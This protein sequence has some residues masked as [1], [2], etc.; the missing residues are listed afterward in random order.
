MAGLSTS[1]TRQFTLVPV[2]L[3][4]LEGCSLYRLVKGG[5]EVPFVLAYGFAFLHKV[6]SSKTLSFRVMKNSSSHAERFPKTLFAL[7]RT[8]SEGRVVPETCSPI[9]RCTP[10]SGM[11]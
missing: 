5:F 7:S 11:E 8:G 3:L 10:A 2:R 4:L 9:R 6:S 1:V